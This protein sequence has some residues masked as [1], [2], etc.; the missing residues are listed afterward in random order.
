MYVLLYL[1]SMAVKVADINPGSNEERG[2]N[3]LSDLREHW[4]DDSYSLLEEGKIS[5]LSVEDV[6]FCSCV[7]IHREGIDCS[8]LT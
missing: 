5:R 3:R 7:H 1:V 2:G 4:M 8:I 6:S